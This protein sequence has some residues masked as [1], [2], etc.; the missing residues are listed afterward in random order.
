MNYRPF[1]STGKKTF[2]A[3]GFGAM[4]LPTTGDEANVVEAEAIEMIRYAIDNGVTFVD[5][6]YIYHGGNSE[7]IVGE[8]LKDG[9]REKVAVATKLPVWSVQTAADFNRLLNEQLERL[10]LPHVDVYHLHCLQAAT[11]PKVRDLG[12]LEWA[13]DAKADGR[14]G[15]L[16]FSFH[17]AYEVFEE[18]LA[19]YD[20]DL[21][22]IQYNYVNE[23]VQAGTR[24]LQLA[25]A[26]GVPV[27]V[28]EPLFGGCLAN[29]PPAVL[30]ILEEAGTPATAADLALRW[31]WN[32]PEV[33]L[34]L[35][36]MSTLE[37]VKQNVASAGVSGV[38]TLSDDEAALVARLVAAFDELS[39]IPCTKCGY[40]MP[41]PH[42]IDIPLNFELHNNA[43]VHGGAS[44][45]L[46]TNL[47]RGMPQETRAESCIACREC[48]EKCPQGIEISARMPEVQ[49]T[50]EG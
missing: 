36:G 6:A 8:A 47:Y 17:D 15:M 16:G 48:E 28:M 13:E 18:I 43:V 1:G 46:N 45:G 19:A 11:W 12:V 49:K 25:H 3:L 41:C 38:G 4:R 2:S 50:F 7:R 14:I 29:L 26:K 33:S 27:V 10:D 20:W 21:C 9:Y 31:L 22:Q 23:Q 37:Q 39:P 34:V 35:S 24:G 40:C 30:R 5:T 32:K 44:R 42:G